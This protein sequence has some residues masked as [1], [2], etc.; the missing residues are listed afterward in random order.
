MRE[1]T[2]DYKPTHFNSIAAVQKVTAIWGF[3]ES[4]FGGI[5][6]ILKIPFTGLIIGSFAV[7]FIFLI[8]HYSKKPI[9]ILRSTMT[10]ILIKAVVSPYAP[11]TAYFAVSLQGLLGFL[12]FSFFKY[13]LLSTILLGVTALTL[14]ALQKIIILTILFGTTFWHSIDLFYES[15]LKELNL[16]VSIL[17]QNISIVLIS[18]YISIHAFAG[19]IVG[20]KAFSIPQKIKQMAD[21]FKID[22][23]KFN[24]N[25]DLFEKRKTNK[26]KKWWQKTS[27]IIILTIFFSLAVYSYF[28]PQFNK[29]KSIEI[30][31]MIIRSFAI[32]LIWFY[33]LSPVI[34]K[35]FRK[36]IVKKQLA[37]NSEINRAISLFPKFK[38][39]LNYAWENSQD[40][41][42]ITRIKNFLYT[43]LIMILIY[44]L[45]E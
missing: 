35:F 5:L 21:M 3:T 41:K 34:V 38:T 6:H 9:M 12:F 18:I 45:N 40:K 20:I 7:L 37:Y 2:W 23:E 13:E 14:S 39:L 44:E 10:V 28:T 17:P 4:V 22:N 29:Q 24:N 19:L 32:T 31:L 27:G 11:L 1:V 26:K 25:I 42:G 15:I 43:S 16:V 33:F 30:L 8:A 36:V